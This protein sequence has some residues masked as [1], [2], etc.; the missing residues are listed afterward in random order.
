MTAPVPSPVS[1]LHTLALIGHL[2]GLALGVGGATVTDL[3]M[4]R[5]I[6]KRRTDPTLRLVLHAASSCVVAGLVLL[7]GS[8][9]LLVATGT[10]PTPRFWAKMLVVVVLTANGTIAHRVTFPRLNRALALG[11]VDITL[12]FLNLLAVTAAVSATSWYSALVLGSWKTAHLQVHEYLAIYLFVMSWAVVAALL[13]TPSL[14]GAP[15]LSGT[16]VAELDD[17]TLPPELA[18]VG[19]RTT[20]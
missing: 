6:R 20:L 15:R 9:L 8:G 3:M 16:I 18:V 11:R 19:G 2:V 5:C 1:T 17:P 10:H 13:V 14:L 12:G 7:V 4:V